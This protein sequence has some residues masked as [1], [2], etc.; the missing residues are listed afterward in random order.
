MGLIVEDGTGLANA[1]AFMSLAEFKAYADAHGYDYSAYDD[2]A[3]IEPAI[4]RGTTYVSSSF[5]WPGYKVKRRAQAL[6]WPRNGAVDRDGETISADAVPAE[7]KSAAGEAAWYEL[8]TGPLSPAVVLTERVKREKIEGIE[9][10]YASAGA[11]A[12]ASLPSLPIID[13]LV[14]GLLASSNSGGGYS[15]ALVRA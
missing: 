12:A 14:S 11:T 1:D 8:A 7:I 5:A 9:V 10:E 13:M 15:S 3:Q 6:A 4:R 2:E